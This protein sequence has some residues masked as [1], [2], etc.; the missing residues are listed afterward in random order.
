MGVPDLQALG[1]PPV[2]R[3][4]T[5]PPMFTVTEAEAAA[6]HTAF[7]QGGEWAAADRL[8]AG[9]PSAGRGRWRGQ[10]QLQTG[11]TPAEA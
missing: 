2:A 9:L 3:L 5:L 6:I 7:D 1:L 8:P 4:L 10:A 11:K